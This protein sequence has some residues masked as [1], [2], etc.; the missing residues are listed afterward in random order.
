M[1]SMSDSPTFSQPD[2]M[3]GP[4]SP[5]RTP[6]QKMLQLTNK[7]KLVK[8]PTPS[9][10]SKRRSQR[11]SEQATHLQ[12]RHGR[13]IASKRV[14]IRYRQSSAGKELADKIDQ[15]LKGQLRVRVPAW[16]GSSS[17]IK[18]ERPRP[19]KPT[20]PFFLGKSAFKEAATA[21]LPT[22][23]GRSTRETSAEPT[24]SK[25]VPWSEIKFTT[26]KLFQPKESNL[27]AAPWPPLTL[28]HLRASFA[29]PLIT[30]HH[31][32]QTRPQEA[33]QKQESVRIDEDEDIFRAYRTGML[34][35]NALKNAVR[36][37]ERLQMTGTDL[38]A[39]LHNDPSSSQRDCES[40]P[41]LRRIQSLALHHQSAF[42]LG[43]ASGPQ[44][45]AHAYAPKC[46]EDLLQGQARAFCEWLSKLKI[47]HVQSKVGSRT[48]KPH[49]HVK[50]GRKRKVKRETDLDDFIVTSDEDEADHDGSCNTVLVLVGPPGCGKTA[51][52]YGIAKELDF[53]IF[54]I[55][56]GMRR[57]A[58]DIYDRVGDMALNHLVHPSAALSRD[59]STLTEPLDQAPSLADTLVSKQPKMATFF[60]NQKQSSRPATPAQPEKTATQ[61]QS[62]ILFEEVDIL[63]EEDRSFW[64]G[65]QH[66]AQHSKRPIILTCHDT[67]SIPY[68]ELN[69][70]DTIIFERPEVDDAVNYLVHLAAAEGHL[71]QKE[72]LK[73]LY[74]GR[75]QDLRA[76][77]TELNFWCQMTVGS[78]LGGLDWMPTEP[79]KVLGPRTI[80]RETFHSGLN[81]VPEANHS[82]VDLLTFA[83]DNLGLPILDW[84]EGRL[85]ATPN[86]G[87]HCTIHD[88][89][90]LTDVR[91][92]MDMI[93]SS[94]AIL[95]STSAS[96]AYP[97]IRAPPTKLELTNSVLPNLSPPPLSR[98][99]FMDIFEPI[100]E[101]CRTFPPTVGRAPAIDGSGSTLIT[102]VAPYVRLIV[103]FDERLEEQRTELAGGSQGGRQRK[104][105]AA[106]AAL[107]GG[108][109]ASTRRE[110]WFP[111]GLD[112]QLVLETQPGDL[113]E[114][115][116]FLS[117]ATESTGSPQ[118]TSAAPSTGNREGSADR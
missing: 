45:W 10:K 57:T 46:A 2:N 95:L 39:A 13:I 7:G 74:L 49:Q 20:H 104:T 11:T 76:S 108:D 86:L 30:H 88:I 115:T 51:T 68:A 5:K 111:D 12:A 14:V 33:K 96:T 18:D 22:T 69:I 73:T 23:E 53:E 15:I 75:G 26:Q 21:A 43:R 41:A 63:F 117:M 52:V 93:D 44:D 87:E 91:S 42:D 24:V 85:F 102:E 92:A 19:G 71:L 56:P 8:T 99:A 118:A 103:G 4:L 32:H 16:E 70:H 80:S 1:Q 59:S 37:P 9:P 97:G 94:S 83:Q 67:D 77:I 110:K 105:R 112:F 36:L 61:K 17:S 54:E 6:K 72:D 50:R 65:V 79:S 60:N 89:S 3:D 55:H 98:K 81:V 38:L 82:E 84:E 40:K 90:L 35:S 106:R 116:D 25:P 64:T 66:L 31:H 58:R 48:D 101:D 62:L 114:D 34:Q 78:R 100:A 29:N 113:G 109:K 28:Q 107:E 47:Q 27:Q